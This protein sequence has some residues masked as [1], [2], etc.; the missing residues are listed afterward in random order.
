MKKNVN[1]GVHQQQSLNA[2][3][4][5]SPLQTDR[6][7][8]LPP[9]KCDPQ[10]SQ[11]DP[12][13]SPDTGWIQ[14][15]ANKKIGIGADATC[16][17]MQTGQIV[18]DTTSNRAVV[19]RYSK[20]I[21][22]CDE[23]ML[24]LFRN[25]VVLDEDGK[26]HPVPVMWGTQEKAVQYILAD[27]VRNDETAVVDRVRLPLMAIRDTS[28]E[29]DQSRYVY[30][31]AL[32][33]MRRLRPDRKPGFTQRERY[34]RDTVF[35]VARGIPINRG[36]TLTAW[37]MYIEDIDQI[38]EQILLK[39]SPIAYINVRGV[40]WETIVTL[41]SIANNVDAEPGEKLRIIKYQFNFTAQTYIPQ[42]I[43]RKKAVLRTKTDI[44]NSVDEEKI[45][46]VF[47]RI[48]EAVEEFEQL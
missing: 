20:A 46:E 16:D 32:D 37:T 44:F 27:N 33:Y 39:F 28:L 4:D 40:Q 47:G 9:E 41:D 14:D 19:Y 1:P 45:T 29:F 35:G 42:P 5:I 48:E 18:N 3:N 31:Q 6:N 2:C 23:A 21:R 24:D 15:A 8:D 12:Y 11:R 13:T 22:G 10:P 25:V 17:P 36:Y 7:T 26:A 43:A 38:L 30:H 34:E